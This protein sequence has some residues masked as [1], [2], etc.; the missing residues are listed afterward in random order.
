MSEVIFDSNDQDVAETSKNAYK[1]IS[2]DGSKDS[3]KEEVRKALQAM[4]GEAT[5]NK[6]IRKLLD[7]KL[8]ENNT[9]GGLKLTDKGLAQVST[10]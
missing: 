8:L 5:I 10:S 1:K 2:E 3:Q 9:N 7:K 6:N 4:G